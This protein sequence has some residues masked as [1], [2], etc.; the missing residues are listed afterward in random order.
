M[1]DSTGYA[2]A[3]RPAP[4]MKAPDAADPVIEETVPRVLVRLLYFWT[5]WYCF[6]SF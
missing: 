3:V 1:Y 4:V 5:C 6:S 2:A